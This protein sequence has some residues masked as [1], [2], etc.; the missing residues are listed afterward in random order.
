MNI[1]HVEVRDTA[2]NAVG[3]QNTLRKPGD[4]TD[5]IQANSVTIEIITRGEPSTGDQEANIKYI[6]DLTT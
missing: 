2:Q 1:L 6:D 4:K 5:I 3:K